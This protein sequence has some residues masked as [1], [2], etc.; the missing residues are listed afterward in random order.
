MSLALTPVSVLFVPA[1]MS[2]TNPLTLF[3]ASCNIRS[4]LAN[5]NWDSTPVPPPSLFISRRLDIRDWILDMSVT[6][7]VNSLLALIIFARSPN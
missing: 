7:S 2:F 3:V 6:W 4:A 1:S 5:S